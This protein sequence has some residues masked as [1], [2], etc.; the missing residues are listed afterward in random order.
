MSL[1]GWVRLLGYYEANLAQSPAF[2]VGIIRLPIVYGPGS[3]VT[4]NT[5]MDCVLHKALS[6]TEQP[7][8][9]R[10]LGK[11]K[12]DLLYVEDAVEAL[13]LIKGPGI[14]KGAIS[15]GSGRA[16]TAQQL[17]GT[18]AGVVGDALNQTIQVAYSSNDTACDCDKVAPL[19]RA[20][21]VLGWQPRTTGSLQQGLAATV[22]WLMGEQN[23]QR[24]L[25]VVA[26]QPRGGQIAWKSMHKHLVLPSSAHLVTLLA[27]EGIDD[28]RSMLETM[29]HWTWRVPEPANMDWGVG[30]DKATTLCQHIDGLHWSELC[31][32]SAPGGIWANWLQV[33]PCPHQHVWRATGVPMAGKQMDHAAEPPQAVRLHHV[34]PPR[35]SLLV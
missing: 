32:A 19:D 24:V 33:M 17:A 34:H 29:A 22:R 8:Q 35:S 12:Q 27:P 16:T 15:I 11:Q 3:N 4:A 20:Q 25:V 28:S 18:L 2:N 5:S 7:P 14:N 31:N 13:L 30:M 6:R 10:V 26:G 1:Y 9:I 23:K 21:S